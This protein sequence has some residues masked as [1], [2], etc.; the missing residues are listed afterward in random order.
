MNETTQNE[1]IITP[2]F[3]RPKEACEYMRIGLSSLWRLAND[4]KLT[5]IK[6]SPKVALFDIKEID[7]LM[8][9]SGLVVA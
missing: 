8:S 1:I 3:L 9:E 4:G 7:K 2:R 5:K 6:L